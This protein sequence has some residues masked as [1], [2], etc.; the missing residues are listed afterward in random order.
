MVADAEI[1]YMHVIAPKEKKKKRAPVSIHP[2]PRNFLL[3]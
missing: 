1:R 2:S 3:S